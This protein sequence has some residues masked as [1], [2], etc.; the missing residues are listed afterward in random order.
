MTHVLYTDKDEDCPGAICDRNGD[1]VLACC[2][3]CGRSECE[4]DEMPECPG[5]K[6]TRSNARA[7]GV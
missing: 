3:V 1:V 2:K 5:T 4:L 6:F 7:I